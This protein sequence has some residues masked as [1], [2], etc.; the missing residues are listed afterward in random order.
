MAAASL[1]IV[2]LCYRD[3]QQQSQGGAS[4]E[5]GRPH[6]C[7]IKGC[8]VG[9]LQQGSCIRHR[10]EVV[11]TVTGG[12]PLLRDPVRPRPPHVLS[13]WRC[14]LQGMAALTAIRNLPSHASP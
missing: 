3:T 6:A 10:C 4:R 13:V 14:M 9:S 5:S 11:A 8:D 1:T 12:P 7:I 2:L